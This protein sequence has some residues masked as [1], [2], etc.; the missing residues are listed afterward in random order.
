MA[1]S[2]AQIAAN[3]KNAQK[4]DRPPPRPARRSPGLTPVTHGL[5][6][7]SIL[8]PG[9]DAAHVKKRFVNLHKE[10][11]PTHEFSES[12]VDR[13]ALM[14]IRLERCGRFDTA[15]YSD[16]VRHALDQYD[17]ARRDKVEM[18][19]A[20]IRFDTSACRRLQTMPEGVDWMLD[21]WEKLR[22]D[23]TRPEGMIWTI[24][25][26]ER[27]RELRGSAGRRSGRAATGS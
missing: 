13:I 22:D 19:A 23:L 20:A 17:N 8:L 15:H 9:E 14:T 26:L 21:E 25:H 1:A 2:Q 24:N 11:A 5:R 27:A 16:R 7:E 4:V 3:R 12:L 10:M 6:A 18:L